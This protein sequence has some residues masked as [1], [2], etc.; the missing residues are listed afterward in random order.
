MIT[1]DE[2][3][4]LRASSGAWSTW[5][6]S[7]P[8]HWAHK[9]IYIYFTRHLNTQE[10]RK[11]NKIFPPRFLTNK[12]GES[13]RGEWIRRKPYERLC[14]LFGAWQWRKLFSRFLC[15]ISIETDGDKAAWNEKFWSAILSELKRVINS[16]YQSNG[17]VAAT[18]KGRTLTTKIQKRK[19]I[20]SCTSS[21]KKES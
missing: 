8:V 16:I 14:V 1:N 7:V 11:R 13:S 10:K 2:D 4:S 20:C 5:P 6:T 19:R 15:T 21:V 3:D 9:N 12:M 18:Q 17:H